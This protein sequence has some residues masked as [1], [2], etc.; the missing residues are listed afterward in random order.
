[1]KVAFLTL[2]ILQL[3]YAQSVLINDGFEVNYDGWF[4]GGD[5]ANIKAHQGLGYNMSRGMKITDRQTPSD[6]AM[7][8][9]N[10]YLYG[11]EECRARFSW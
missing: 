10:F 9:K 6:G 11:G 7:S 8:E 3:A 4:A 5:F 2:L 1:M